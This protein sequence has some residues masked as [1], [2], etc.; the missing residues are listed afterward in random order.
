MLPDN[1]NCLLFCS[2][3]NCTRLPQAQCKSIC[4]C[5]HGDLAGHLM[6]TALY[7]TVVDIHALLP[8]L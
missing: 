3:V 1:L 8:D 4:I 5:C 7:V 6:D 2:M